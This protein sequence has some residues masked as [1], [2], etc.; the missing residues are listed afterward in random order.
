MF[1]SLAL[2]V[3]ELFK[4]GLDFKNLTTEVSCMST[5]LILLCAII[6]V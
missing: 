6:V 4:L 2:N 1:T 3:L 5:I